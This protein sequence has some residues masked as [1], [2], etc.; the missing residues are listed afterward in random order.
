MITLTV[1]S[2][3]GTAV[4]DL[5]CAFDELGGTVGRAPTNQLVLPD[6]ERS[7][8]RVQA[9]VGFR[10]GAYFLTARGAIVM[11]HNG[12]SMPVS[13]EVQLAAG[14]QL[15]IG[16]Y[17]I[18]VS[19]SAPA[20]VA[21][22]PFEAAFGG[23]KG[24]AKPAPIATGSV[25]ALTVP[26]PPAS[27]PPPAAGQGKTSGGGIP[28]DW[29]PFVDTKSNPF[30]QVPGSQAP[31]RQSSQDAA[32]IAPSSAENSLDAM[33]GL[34]GG[35]PKGDP[36]A[37]SPLATGSGMSKP[38]S[39]TDGGLGGLMQSAKARVKP[40]SD[41]VSDLNA[42]W[43]NTPK[44]VTTSSQSGVVAPLPGAVL[45]WDT[46]KPDKTILARPGADGAGA[47]LAGAGEAPVQSASGPA[48]QRSVFAEAP[49]TGRVAE[50]TGSSSPTR[51]AEL[52]TALQEGLG[53]RE[54]RLGPMSPELLR[55][56]G[57]LLRESTKGTVE[58]LAARAA[59][60]REVRAD[61]TTILANSNNSLKFSPTAEVALQYMLGPKV[62]GFL[63]PVESM[64]DAYD[65]LRAHQLGV[66]AGVKAAL[67]G[68]VQRFDPAVVERKL[69]T[70]S[71]RSSLIPSSRKARLW[72]MFE[73]M[74]RQMASEAEE[75]FNA[76]FGE[77]FLTAYQQYIDQLESQAGPKA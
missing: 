77:T 66:M 5:A 17:R 62:G 72:E 70:T 55:L 12:K 13:G 71:A 35:A 32:L 52:L 41:H 67:T 7:I 36:L 38:G 46:P 39:D 34:K 18:A 10:S 40:E 33:F 16:G 11:V 30:N 47:S 1:T 9:Q 45:S 74:Y 42:P 73:E 59:L 4:S 58:L 65:D 29:D 44:P 60:K 53:A 22:D 64:R 23:P 26:P 25:K 48:P 28:D 75:D 21:A 20:S 76:L 57:Q 15:E 6:P 68:V 49:K 51:D 63:P 43:A 50:G 61:V 3:N 8:S 31:L 2:F 69:S 19:D 27:R 24:D 54:L 37:A 14:D 56:V